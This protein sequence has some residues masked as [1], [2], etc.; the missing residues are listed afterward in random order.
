MIFQCD[1]PQKIAI[2]TDKKATDLHGLKMD[3]YG[4]KITI[5]IIIADIISC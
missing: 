5:L 1:T 4:R 2:Q 3:N